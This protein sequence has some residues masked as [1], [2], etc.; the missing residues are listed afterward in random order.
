VITVRASFQLLAG[1]N[2]CWYTAQEYNENPKN[3]SGQKKRV[4]SSRVDDAQTP[5]IEMLCR[6]K[7]KK[8]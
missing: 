2:N 8:S 3:A 4:C 6:Q 7:S 1:E 5:E